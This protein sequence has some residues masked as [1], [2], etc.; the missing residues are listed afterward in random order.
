MTVVGVV[1]LMLLAP[2]VAPHRRLVRLALVAVVIMPAWTVLT[3]RWEDLD[4]VL[5]S[6]FAV[7]TVRAVARHRPVF[8]GLG[9][10][11]IAAKPWAIGFTPIVV[12]LDGG[13]LPRPWWSPLVWP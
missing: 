1:L 13:L 2:V 6:V 10:G 3:V 7:A 11:A 8:A 4:D 5:A 12:A 9:P